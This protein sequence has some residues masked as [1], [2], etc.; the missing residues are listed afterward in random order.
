M[1]QQ[2]QKRKTELPYDPVIP[3]LDIYPKHT[4]TLIWKDIYLYVYC[5]II[6]NSQIMEA[7]QESSDR[8][9][10]E[11]QVVN[12]YTMEYY[13]AINKNEILPFATNGWN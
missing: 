4:K 2:Q 11:E 9:K 13:L 5:S 6:C 3:L 8:W 7:A 10:D 1:K 12:I